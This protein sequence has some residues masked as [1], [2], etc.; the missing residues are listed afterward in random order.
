[1]KVCGR[2]FLLL[3]GNNDGPG[4]TFT[5]VGGAQ[6]TGMTLNNELVE[7]TSKD[8]GEWRQI[9]EAC[10]IGSMSISLSGVMDDEAKLL[11]VQE[12]GVNKTHSNYQIVSDLGDSFEAAFAVAS[13]ERSG[14]TGDAEKFSVTLESAGD[15][16]FTPIP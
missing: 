2:L 6:S 7:I 12:D 10:G 8:D 15:V 9:L 4:E 11:E 13:F 14:D 5:Q 1:M 16:V 3:K